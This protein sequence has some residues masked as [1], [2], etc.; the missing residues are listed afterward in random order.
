V[1]AYS[2][3]ALVGPA[4]LGLGMELSDPH[5]FAVGL[6]LAFLAYIALLVV[7]IATAKA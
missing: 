7:R 5:G 4:I 1:F 3:G 2:S 6:G